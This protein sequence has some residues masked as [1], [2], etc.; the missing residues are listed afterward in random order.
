MT[1]KKEKN[2]L[3]ITK[4]ALLTTIEEVCSVKR[5]IPFFGIYQILLSFGVL[6]ESDVEENES[7]IEEGESDISFDGETDKEKL[8]EKKLLL[9]QIDAFSKEKSVEFAD[10]WEGLLKSNKVKR[11]LSQT[12]PVEQHCIELIFENLVFFVLYFLLVCL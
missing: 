3:P 5:R 6:I 4:E 10:N 7:P 2:E 11:A 1:E 12:H 9:A 8:K